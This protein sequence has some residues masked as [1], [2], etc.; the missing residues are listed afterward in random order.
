[1]VCVSIKM[2]NE[3]YKSGG[4]KVANKTRKTFKFNRRCQICRKKSK[5]TLLYVVPY[6][7]V[8]NFWNYIIH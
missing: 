6:I 4:Q 2:M 7:L 1:M 5:E 8:S 3:P